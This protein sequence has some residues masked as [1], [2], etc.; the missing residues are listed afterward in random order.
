MHLGVPARVARLNPHRVSACP[1][2]P[3]PMNRKYHFPLAVVL[4]LS[5]LSG[6]VKGEDPAKN[7]LVTRHAAPPGDRYPV[8]LAPL[9]GIARPAS[10]VTMS[11]TFEGML[12]EVRVQEGQRVEQG[13]I[14]AVVDN[15][16]AQAAVKVARAAADHTGE[17]QQAREEL[18]FAKIH[19]DRQLEFKAATGG[20]G[21]ELLEAE[22]RHEKAKAA[23]LV[24]EQ[25]QRRAQESLNLEIAR[26]Q[27][28]DIRAPFSGEILRLHA[29]PGATLT[30]DDD[31]LT[32][33]CVDQLEV[34]LYIPLAHYEKLQ[35]GREYPLMAGAPVNRTVTASLKYVAPVI[36]SAT[37]AVRTVF[38]LDN[39]DQSLPAGFPAQLDTNNA[40]ERKSLAGFP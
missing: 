30:R 6:T 24:A 18:N 25:D 4:V 38:A 23:L 1:I 13:E 12:M 33:I 10:Q 19:L 35:V 9:P 31:L 20:A 39:H 14:L 8:E 34:D 5:L 15:H 37:S 36:D 28:H 29:R 26:L 16:I 22:T 21:F 3:S 2:L 11:A 17:I 27:A 32:I 7:S 40:T